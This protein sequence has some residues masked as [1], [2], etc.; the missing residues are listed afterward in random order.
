MGVALRD[1]HPQPCSPQLVGVVDTRPHT[2][3]RPG[4]LRAHHD[5]L[6]HLLFPLGPFLQE[7]VENRP[8]RA[9]RP[10]ERH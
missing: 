7:A 3:R 5:S 4:D 10:W 1:T 9:P 6:L 8:D 2:A